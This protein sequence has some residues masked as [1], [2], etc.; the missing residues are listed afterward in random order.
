VERICASGLPIPV[1]DLLGVPLGGREAGG[2]PKNPGGSTPCHGT[3]PPWEDGTEAT[4]LA[5]GGYAFPDHVARASTDPLWEDALV[6][7]STPW[8]W[9]F[10]QDQSQI[11]GFYGEDSSWEASAVAGEQL[12]DWLEARGAETALLLTWGRR[13]GDETNP[14]LFPDFPTMQ[15]E[16]TEGYLAYRDRFATDAR[17]V[18]VAPAGLAFAA[19]YAAEADPADPTS[20]FY[21]LYDVDGSHPS[22]AGTWLVACVVF[23]T[24]TGR[25]AEPVTPLAGVDATEA[26]LLAAT[27]WEVVSSGAAGLTYPWTGDTPTDTGATNSG[28]DTGAAD[29]ATPSVQSDQGKGCGC[30]GPAAPLW[31]GVVA[32]GLLRRRVAGTA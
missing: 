7:G 29:S 18:W 31:L 10:L 6:T 28:N 19:V 15:D 23:S 27:A 12:D 13:D 17:P 14:Q 1:L 22:P 26:E 25:S 20:L 30:N 9:G 2:L 4:R 11:P 5:E 16:L 3:E 8:A 32:V 24:I 21:R